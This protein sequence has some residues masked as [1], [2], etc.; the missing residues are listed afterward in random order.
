MSKCKDCEYFL[1]M[2]QECECPDTP[3]RKTDFCLPDEEAC[4]YF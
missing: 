3:Q 1:S 2:Y 4:E